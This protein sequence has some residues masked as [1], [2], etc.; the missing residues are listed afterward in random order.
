M[1]VGATVAGGATH[2]LAVLSH[3]E[4]EAAKNA[5][6]KLKTLGSQLGSHRGGSTESATVYG[7][8]SGKPFGL[9]ASTLIHGQGSDTFK[10]GARTAPTHALANIGNDTVVSGSATTLHGRTQA[11]RFGGRSPQHFNLSSDTISVQGAT[12]EAIKAATHHE[13]AKAG[14]HTVTLADKTTVTISGLSKHDIG[15]LTH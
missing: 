12:A 8:V 1:V 4:R 11:E 2:G 3:A 6:A 15:K 14:T 10:G 7:G 13:E 5:L 9:N